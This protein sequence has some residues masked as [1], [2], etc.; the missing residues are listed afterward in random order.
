MLLKTKAAL[1]T[2]TL[3]YSN[4]ETGSRPYIY[5]YFSIF[6]WIILI[7]LISLLGSTLL[8]HYLLSLLS[9][10]TL[11]GGSQSIRAFNLLEWTQWGISLWQKNMEKDQD[12]YVSLEYICDVGKRWKK[13]RHERQWN[14]VAQ[15]RIWWLRPFLDSRRNREERQREEGWWC[16]R[17]SDL[18]HTSPVLLLT[19][20]DKSG[21]KFL[22]IFMAQF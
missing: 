9:F 12:N 6:I 1:I 16:A 21:F 13:S 20:S 10:L 22:F 18:I 8:V 11:Q 2:W 5:Q 17:A 3:L 14:S 7:L 19:P 4:S 15:T